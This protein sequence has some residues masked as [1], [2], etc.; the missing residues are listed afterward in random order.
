[1][2]KTTTAALY[3]TAKVAAEVGT[4]SE[5]NSTA[6]PKHLVDYHDWIV[7]SH[8]DSDYMVSNL[9]AQSL[10]FFARAFGAKRILEIGSYVGYSALVWAHAVG[11]DGKVTGLE[12][13]AEYAKIANDAFEKNSVKNVEI[14]V[15]DA[16]Q[17]LS[18]LKPEEPYDLIFIDAQKSGYPSYLRDI[19]AG[20]QPGSTT[21]LLRPGGIIIADN[22]L[23]RALVADGSEDNPNWQLQRHVKHAEDDL[24]ALRKFNSA[25]AN[26]ERLEAFLMP[27]FDGVGFARLLN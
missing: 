5:R 27:V 6:L 8:P 16:L 4:Y 10:V 2:T 11:Q 23:R 3:P 14:I 24:T 9:Q 19:L 25:L 18:T 20:S 15:G 12:F 22:V 1:M 7:E 21:R 26:D 13:S 17:T